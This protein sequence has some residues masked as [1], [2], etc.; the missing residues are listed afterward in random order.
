MAEILVTGGKGFIGTNLT[1]ELRRKGH[2][3]VTCDIIQHHDP[4]HCKADCSE[5]QQME[6]LFRKHKFDFVYHQQTEQ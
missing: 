1:N 2:N 3:V 4:Q 5:Y 6:V